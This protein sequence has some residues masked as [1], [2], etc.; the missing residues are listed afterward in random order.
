ME[1]ANA[2]P[3]VSLQDGRFCLIFACTAQRSV[4]DDTYGLSSSKPCEHCRIA[5]SELKPKVVLSLLTQ[6]G[7]NSLNMPIN[8]LGLP[9]LQVLLWRKAP[10]PDHLSGRPTSGAPLCGVSASLQ[11]LSRHLG[12]RTTNVG[13]PRQDRIVDFSLLAKRGEAQ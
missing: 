9:C 13:G 6:N 2:A 10:L 12:C 4:L 5:W 7:I 8:G 1:G 11:H 3:L